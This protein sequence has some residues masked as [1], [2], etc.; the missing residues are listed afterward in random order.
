LAIDRLYEKS[1]QL[2][3]DAEEVRD[4]LRENIERWNTYKACREEKPYKLYVIGSCSGI[5]GVAFGFCNM[6]KD[7]GG[8]LDVKFDVETF[9][10]GTSSSFKVDVI[11]PHTRRSNPITG[12]MEPYTMDGAPPTWYAHWDVLMGRS[13]ARLQFFLQACSSVDGASVKV[14]ATPTFAGKTYPTT[15]QTAA[16]ESECDTSDLCSS[17][18]V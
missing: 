7:C 4:L 10:G 3:K 6:D 18:S 12:Q 2:A 14:S 5:I 13:G 15:V 1:K 17:A 16:V 9:E 8:P 11:K